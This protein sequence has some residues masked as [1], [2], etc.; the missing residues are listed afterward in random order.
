MH[1]ALGLFAMGVQVDDVNTRHGIGRGETIA[2]DVGWNWSFVGSVGDE[3]GEKGGCNVQVPME[4]GEQGQEV[5]ETDGEQEEEAGLLL[6]LLCGKVAGIDA[7]L[8]LAWV[9][10]VECHWSSRMG[11]GVTTACGFVI[12]SLL[13]DLGLV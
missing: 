13:R 11:V 6:C 10:K 4:V 5:E 9:S 12:L 3:G 2:E 7:V 8:V 1:Q